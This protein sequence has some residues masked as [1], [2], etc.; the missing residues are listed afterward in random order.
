MRLLYKIL[1]SPMLR[2]LRRIEQDHQTTDIRD[3]KVHILGS[4]DIQYKELRL[5]IKEN[6][7]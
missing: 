6:E 1:Y 4:R 5:R 3:D 7:D 2:I